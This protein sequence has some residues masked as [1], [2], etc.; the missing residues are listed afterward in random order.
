MQAFF[1]FLCLCVGDSHDL[2]RYF[3]KPKYVCKKKKSVQE[4]LYFI[5]RIMHV[6]LI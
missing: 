4:D 2:T 5:Q 6:V 3:L 1:L